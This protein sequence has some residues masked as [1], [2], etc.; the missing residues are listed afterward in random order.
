M[1]VKDK[2]EKRE[3]YNVVDDQIRTPT[4]VGDLAVGIVK[5]I[6]KKATGFYHLS[7]KN[8]LT[9]YEMAIDTAK[10]LGLDS[11]LINRVTADNFKLPAKRPPKTGF[12]IAK[13]IKEID[14]DPISFAEGLAKT[15]REHEE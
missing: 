9:P 11:S 14:F 2:L 8:I 15:F 10:F 6:E 12:D 7:G 3:I 5:I 13:A 1:V 4:Y